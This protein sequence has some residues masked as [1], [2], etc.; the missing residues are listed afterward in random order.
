MYGYL[1]VA[2]H[3]RDTS[4][5]PHHGSALLR[6]QDGAGKKTGEETAHSAISSP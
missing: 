6:R 4:A 5:I 3:R 2:R 1:T